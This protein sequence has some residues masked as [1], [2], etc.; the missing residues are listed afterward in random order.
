LGLKTGL[1]TEGLGAEAGLGAS[2]RG[3]D[4]TAGCVSLLCSI[5]SGMDFNGYFLLIGFIR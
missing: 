3:V 5:V 1:G 2:L 4:E